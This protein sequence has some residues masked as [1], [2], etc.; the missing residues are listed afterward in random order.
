MEILKFPNP[1][2]L[3]P[4][5]PVTV[6][7]PEL[8]TILDSM[9]DTMVKAN[10]LGLS[11]NQVNLDMTMFVMLGESGARL[12]VVNPNILSCSK[13]TYPFKEGCLSSPGTF[14]E[15]TERP[16]WTQIRFQDYEGNFCTATLFRIDSICVN[17][18]IEHLQGKSFLQSKSIPRAKRRQLCGRWGLKP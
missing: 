3:K 15:I 1:T 13:L 10:G 17:H 14:A 11:A 4:C 6:F 9:Y 7:G 2:L 18:E 12:N 16:L 8:K 5:K